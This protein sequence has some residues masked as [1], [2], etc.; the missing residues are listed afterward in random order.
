MRVQAIWFAT[1]QWRLR[2]YMRKHLEND[3]RNHPMRWNVLI[4]GIVWDDGKGEYDVSDLPKSWRAVVAADHTEAAIEYALTDA[5]DSCG[6]L[7][8]SY[9]LVDVQLIST[10]R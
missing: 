9:L 3:R 6:S 10:E 4:K 8:E 5:S 2:R 7:I 1:W